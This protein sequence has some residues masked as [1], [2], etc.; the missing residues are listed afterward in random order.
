MSSVIWQPELSPE[1][2]KWRRLAQTLTT[3]QFAGL[4]EELDRDGRYPWESVTKLVESKLT[5]IFVPSVYGG[6]GSNLTATVAAIEAIGTGCSTTAAI[7][8]ALQLGAFPILLAGREDQKLFYLGEMMKGRATSFALSERSTGSDPAA[9]TTIAVREGAGWRIRGEKYWIGNGGA[10]RYYIVFAKTDL[11]PNGRGISAFIVDKESGGV[12]ID[13]LVDKMGIR[14]TQTS[15]LRLDTV[16]GEDA[17]IGEPNR[18]LRLAFETLNVGR[19]VVAAQSVGL[20]LACY[21]EASRRAVSR[22]TFGSPIIE[23]QAVSFRL[24]DMAVEISAARMMLY[25]AAQAYDGGNS[26]ANIGAMAKL[27]GSE[28]SHRAADAAVQIWGGLGYCKPS[29]VER[30]YRDQRILEIYEG[31]SEIQRL[32]LSRAIRKEVEG[33]ATD[34]AVKR[35]A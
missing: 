26:V 3:E 20:A 29:V 16:V 10:S 28:V 13:E 9:I 32:V 27:F 6:A 34:I 24:A 25:E 2:E 30:L 31:S 11:I 14:G 1:A 33:E 23:N 21:R 18:A 15:N 22:S 12:V 7:L 17:R 35:S 4:A 5:G 19:I 8:C